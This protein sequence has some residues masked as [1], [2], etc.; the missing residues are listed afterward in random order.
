M[1]PTNWTA[2]IARTNTTTTLAA[3]FIG[4]ESVLARNTTR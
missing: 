2:M 1:P 4:G 3:A